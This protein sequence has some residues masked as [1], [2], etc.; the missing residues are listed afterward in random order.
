MKPIYQAST[1]CLSHDTEHETLTST[2]ASEGHPSTLPHHSLTQRSY[3][4]STATDLVAYHGEEEVAYATRESVQDDGKE[5]SRKFRR[6]D[7]GGGAK[8]HMSVAIT[9]MRYWSVQ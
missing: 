8:G 4:S 1:T 3:F 2:V 5:R 6:K 9:T 7:P